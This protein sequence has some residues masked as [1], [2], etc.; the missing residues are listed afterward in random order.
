MYVKKSIFLYVFIIMTTIITDRKF[1]IKSPNEI[2]QDK[3]E[4]LINEIKLNPYD[5]NIEQNEQV[6]SNITENNQ[7]NPFKNT[8]IKNNTNIKSEK[9]EIKP[10]KKNKKYFIPK[11]Y[12]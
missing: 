10:L 4:E 12:I 2:L 11:Y 1:L 5:T 8:L 9:I 7:L 3:I 6:Y